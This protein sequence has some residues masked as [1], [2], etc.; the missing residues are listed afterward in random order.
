[1]LLTTQAYNIMTSARLLAMGFGLN[2]GAEESLDFVAF[3]N[4]PL[5][6]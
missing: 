6:L 4:K 1:M 3:E 2:R 5:N